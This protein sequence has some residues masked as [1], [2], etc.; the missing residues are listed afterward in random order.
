MNKYFKL[1]TV[2]IFL[3]FSFNFYAQNNNGIDFIEFD[4]YLN[5]A[6]NDWQIPGMAVAIVQGDS[7]AFVKGYGIREFGKK[8]KVDAKTLFAVA[9]NTKSFTS[10]ALS[11]LVEQGKISWDD[12]VTVHLSYF[13]LYDPYVTGEMT[14]RDLL[15]HRSGLKTFSGDLLWYETNYSRKEVIERARYLKPE[16]GFRTHFGYSNIMFS[17]AGEIILSVTGV[18]WEDYI[19]NNFFKKLEMENSLLSVSELKDKTNIAVPHHIEDGTDPLPVKYMSWDN[20]AAAAAVI[21][22]AE[23]MSQWLIMHMNEGI[24]KN[25]T[26]L[27]ELQIWEMQ[28]MHTPDNNSKSWQSYFPTLHFNAY[29]LGWSLFD[30]QG[31]KVVCHGGGADGMISQ[32]MFV[33]EKDFG[34]VVLTN[35]INYLPAALMYYIID[36]YFGEPAKDWSSFYLRIYKYMNNMDKKDEEEKLKNRVLNTKASLKISDYTGTY[37]G[38]LY[39]NAEVTTEDGHLVLD[40][41]PSPVLIGDLSHLHY[42]TFIIKLRN[43]PTLPDGTVNFIIG[44]DGKV[45]ELRVDIPNPD[46]HFTELEFKKLD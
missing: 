34:I 6:L 8:D 39:G 31:V 17:A 33:P 44:T 19:R 41:L 12:K 29:G 2:S 35:S 10:G 43:S 4:K 13:K 27:D 5:K 32:T 24:Y 23:D 46:F 20:V 7:I 40:F 42:N 9:S 15:C 28:S 16:Y 21:S 37:G 18:S 26:I 25:D 3:I 36:D 22:N 11:Q 38:D 14:I 45:E 1:F 30:Y